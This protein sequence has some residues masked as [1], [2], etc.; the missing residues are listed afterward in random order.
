MNKRTKTLLLII[1]ILIL[2]AI[3]LKGID[4]EGIILKRLYP[5]SYKEVVYGCSEQNKVDPLLTFAIIKAESNF[6]HKSVSTSNAKGLMQLMDSTADEMAEKLELEE[7][8][9]IF[10]AETNILI[11]TKYISTLL[12]YY[13]NNMYLAL[14]AYNAGIGNVNKWIEEGIIKE[15]GSDIENIPFKE[16]QN[17]VRKVIRN[18]RIYERVNS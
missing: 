3:I 14:A 5:M 10:D 13:N 11:G 9:N 1:I 7:D 2:I 16:T 15:D 17:Y 18:Y 8:Y 6:D 4:I 12:Q